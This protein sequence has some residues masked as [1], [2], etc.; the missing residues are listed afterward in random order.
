[1]AWVSCPPFW[2]ILREAKAAAALNHPYICGI[3]EAG[4]IEERL[5][6]AMDYIEGQTL[7]ERLRQGPLPLAQ[8]VPLAAEIAEV[9]DFGLA[10]RYA[11]PGADD[12]TLG[13]SLVTLTGEGLT[14]GTPAYMSPEQLRG[15]PLDPRSDIF[16]FGVVLYE[17]LAGRHPFGQEHGLTTANAILGERYASMAEVLAD[18]KGVVAELQGKAKPWFK[19]LRL[20][21]TAVVV[22]GAVLGAA[23]L[24]K[25]LFFETPAQAL[26]FRERDWV[27]V[28]DFEN[29]TGE[30]VFDAGL[31]TSM[32]VSIQQSQYVNVF[33]PGR[34]KEET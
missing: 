34:V 28:T 25:T 6:F 8:A 17:M 10:K 7:R 15:R 23:W 21:V 27:L 29:L 24:A 9:M 5:F 26:A 2:A 33:P 19:P 12:T 14:P 11:G 4:E 32:T 22:A 13:G 31:E 18:L 20:A 16:S 3:H 30:A 1:M